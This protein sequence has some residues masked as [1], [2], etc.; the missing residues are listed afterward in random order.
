MFNTEIWQLFKNVIL[1]QFNTTH[2]QMR[3]GKN[4]QFKN[5]ICTA[6]A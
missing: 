3:L 5:K 2:E 1:I 6:V 4:K